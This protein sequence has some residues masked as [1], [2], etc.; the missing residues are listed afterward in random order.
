MIH[1]FVSLTVEGHSIGGKGELFKP[2]V[3]LNDTIKLSRLHPAVAKRAK[4][5]LWGQSRSDC[6][7]I[8]LNMQRHSREA[9][10][11]LRRRDEAASL[12]L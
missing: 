5:A 3:D 7:P 10:V 6:Y 4:Y 2:I 8:L 1:T 11:M 12:I 9:T